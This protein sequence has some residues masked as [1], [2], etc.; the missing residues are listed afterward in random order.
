M[1]HTAYGPKSVL[2]HCPNS[3]LLKFMIGFWSQN[4]YRTVIQ[5]EKP[6]QVE[7]FLYVMYKLRKS[8][9]EDGSELC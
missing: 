6:A 8:H 1:S 5:A 9:L 7:V 2:S 3:L 4:G